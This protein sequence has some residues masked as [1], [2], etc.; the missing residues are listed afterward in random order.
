MRLT[1]DFNA[2]NERIPETRFSQY[3]N[4]SSDSIAD[5]HTVVIESDTGIFKRIL[6]FFFL[7]SMGWSEWKDPSPAEFST[8]YNEAPYYID[9]YLASLLS[10]A[11]SEEIIDGQDSLF[12]NELTEFVGL[13]G[14]QGLNRIVDI[15]QRNIVGDQ[16]VG[17]IL[18]RLGY[19]EDPTTEKYRFMLLKGA[20]SDDSIHIR[21]GAILGISALDGPRA[22]PVLQSILQKETSSLLRSIINHVIEHFRNENNGL[23][24]EDN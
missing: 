8:L 24:I 6:P 4:P 19:I 9:D 21:Y 20:L 22:I 23:C 11:R 12:A 3:R 16:I 7:N 5:F 15:I 17:E 1:R 2:T 18:R 10:I 14:A 13:Y